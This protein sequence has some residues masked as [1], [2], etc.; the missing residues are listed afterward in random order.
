MSDKNDYVNSCVRSAT[1]LH[2]TLPSLLKYFNGQ[3]GLVYLLDLFYL[4][5][6]VQ[7]N[8]L[9][10]LDKSKM[11]LLLWRVETTSCSGQIHACGIQL[12]DWR[13]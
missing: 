12:K 7:L 11:T 8:K 4:V 6:F 1:E 3:V 13:S 10:R 5:S 2:V 9:D